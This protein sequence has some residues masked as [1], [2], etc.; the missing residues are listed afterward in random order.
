MRLGAKT[1]DAANRAAMAW[2]DFRSLRRMP[3]SRFTTG[4]L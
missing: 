4:G 1:S 3:S 2:A